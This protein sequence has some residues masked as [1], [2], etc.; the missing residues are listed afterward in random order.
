MFEL[1]I[2]ALPVR[3]PAKRQ[4]H[5]STIRN[6]LTTATYTLFC[7]LFVALGWNE[8]IS[9]EHV[10]PVSVILETELGNIELSLSLNEAPVAAS[11]LLEYIDGGLYDGAT[12]Y[13][14]ASLDS[15]PTP[16]IIQ[17][18]ILAAALNTNGT[19]N[20]ADY[21]V[22]ALL[23]LW[24]STRESGLLHR[25]GSVSLARDLLSTGQVI[26]ELVLCLRDVP[27]MDASP[28]GRPDS[29]GFPVIGE[30]VTGMTLLNSVTDRELEGATR[31][32]FLQGQ[33]LTTPVI[34]TRAYRKNAAPIK[35]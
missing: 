20:P 25:K 17:G 1:S 19:V 34:I 21:G 2:L 6:K 27:S 22:T 32:S 28:N 5:I 11:Y 16:Q 23:P 14:S 35:R 24:E 29:R 7:T 4:T 10:D 13:R 31:I 3:T 8:C 30:V 9:A 15:N 18:G 12:L 33:I 26:P